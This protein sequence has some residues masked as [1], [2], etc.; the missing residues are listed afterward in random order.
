MQGVRAYKKTE[1]TIRKSPKEI[2]MKNN[3]KMTMFVVF[4]V[5]F[6]ASNGLII[7]ARWH[8]QPIYFSESP[9]AAR[10]N[11]LKCIIHFRLKKHYKQYEPTLQQLKKKYEVAMKEK[12]L[13]K[14]ECDRAVGQVSGLQNTLRSMETFKSGSAVMREG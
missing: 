11:N 5:F 10:K 9:K 6:C 4:V 3:L 2:N 13:S 1:C 7:I 8:K 12:M 14:L